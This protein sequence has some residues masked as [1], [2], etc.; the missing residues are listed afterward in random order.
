MADVDRISIEKLDVDN[1]ATWSTRMKW[2]L[3]TKSLWEPVTQ[4]EVADDKADGKALALIGL[5]VKDH[6]IST[7][8]GCETA[9]QA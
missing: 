4:A 2:L 6:H 7:L 9:K 8:G 3:T 5:S 1:Y